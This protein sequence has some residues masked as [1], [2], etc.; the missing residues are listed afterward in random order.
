MCNATNKTSLLKSKKN[1][2][3]SSLLILPLNFAPSPKDILC[4][5]G[6][7]FSNHEG[8]RFFGSIIRQ[9]LKQYREASSRPEKIRVVD[10]ILQE[11]KSNGTRFAK[12]DSE[13]KR[14]YELNDVLAH[15][16]IGHAIRDTI[17]L[18]KDRK[19]NSVKPVKSMKQSKIAKRKRRASPN[20]VLP[21]SKISSST[22]RAK[23]IDDIL[24]MSI[25]TS[26][27]LH[28]VWGDCENKPPIKP[29]SQYTFEVKSESQ[30][31]IPRYND[32]KKRMPSFSLKD[33]YP[34]EAFSFS[35]TTFFGDFQ[36]YD[37]QLRRITSQ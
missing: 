14:W 28:D 18:L 13:D 4:G 34:E 12:L 10:D 30:P 29:N 32:K 6:N 21:G 35:P 33:E 17:R 20:F 27:F 2:K 1:H 15:Q 23:T 37:T 9:N 8:N 19:K 7:V 26:E 31:L 3:L 5:L 16:K 24:R 25:E 22:S 11:I 36:S